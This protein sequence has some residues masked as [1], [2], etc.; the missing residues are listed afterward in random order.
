MNNYL[1]IGNGFIGNIVAKYLNCQIHKGRIE[2]LEDAK[3]ACQGYEVIIN[4]AGLASVD[5]CEEQP[6]QAIKE[7]VLLPLL[8]KMSCSYLVHFSTG[9]LADG[10]LWPRD[11]IKSF[12]MY[13]KTKLLGESY[14]DLVLRIRIPFGS[15][16]HPREFITKLKKFSFADPSYQSFTCIDDML[17]VMHDL[18]L[19][20]DEG[21]RHLVNKGTISPYEM[22]KYMKVFLPMIGDNP[23]KVKRVSAILECPEINID[24][25]HSF[26]KIIERRGYGTI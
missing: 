17:P 21:I 9:C 4:C 14:A 25:F 3:K 13:G 16:E 1:V 19:K 15:M 24:V 6:D 2:T 7:N 5:L 23:G 12:S 26:R 10:T 11:K 18:I 20:R 8:L 22:A